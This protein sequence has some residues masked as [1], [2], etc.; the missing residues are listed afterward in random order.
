[1]CENG[2]EGFTAKDFRTWG[3]TLRAIAYLA[4]QECEPEVSERE[5]KRC[6]AQTAQ[7]V[8]EALRN[9]PA[10]CRKS[11]INPVVFDAWRSGAVA[12]LVP[13]AAISPR[14]LEQIALKLLRDEARRARRKPPLETLL[15]KSLRRP[16][17]AP[18]RTAPETRV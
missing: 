13:R 2:D 1:M 10:V 8:S 9:T 14:G 15:K 17:T 4:C 18:S 3:G 11:Y 5:L 16:R 12:R 7:Q 6:I